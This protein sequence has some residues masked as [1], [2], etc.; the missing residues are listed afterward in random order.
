MAGIDLEQRQR[1]AKTLDAVPVSAD[2]EQ[3]AGLCTLVLDAGGIIVACSDGMAQM[4]G[5]SDS[6]F[7]GDKIWSL[8]PG[9]LRSYSSPSYNGRYLVYLSSQQ[10]WRRFHAV[11]LMGQRFIVELAVSRTY[12]DGRPMFLLKLRQPVAESRLKAH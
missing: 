9:I 10:E 2:K 7:P 6:M 8:I 3:Q 4:F 5:A 11:D 12:T 1:M